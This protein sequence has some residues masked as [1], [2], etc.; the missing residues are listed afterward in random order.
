VPLFDKSSKK[1]V[2]EKIHSKNKKVQGKLSS[3]LDLN[4]VPPSRIVQIHEATG[5]A[6]KMSVGEMEN[7][8]ATLKDIIKELESALIPHLYFPV[9]LLQCSLGRVLMEHQNLAPD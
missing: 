5:E 3:E 6:L 8:N 7:E 9:Q 1:L 2:I 4:G